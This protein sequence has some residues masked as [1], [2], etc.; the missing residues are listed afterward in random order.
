[1]NLGALYGQIDK[2]VF[3]GMLPDGSDSPTV[4]ASRTP[5]YTPRK[6]AVQRSKARTKTAPPRSGRGSGAATFSQPDTRTPLERAPVGQVMTLGGVKGFK[7]SK[8]K[9]MAKIE[10]A[11]IVDIFNLKEGETINCKPSNTD[12]SNS[13]L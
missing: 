9:K 3:G 12:I 8:G 1:M 13:K 7:N 6:E 10:N 11:S 4:G 2:N 5:K